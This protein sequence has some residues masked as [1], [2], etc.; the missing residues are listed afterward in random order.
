MKTEM[1]ELNGYLIITSLDDKFVAEIEI[2]TGETFFDGPE[3]ATIDEIYRFIHAVR[4]RYRKFCN[5]KEADRF[6]D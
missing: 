4:S 2:Q 5:S 6:T 1:T 3:S